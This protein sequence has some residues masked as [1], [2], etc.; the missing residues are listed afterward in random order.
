[1]PNIV[2]NPNDST[3]VSLRKIVTLATG[4]VNPHDSTEESLRKVVTLLGNGAGGTGNTA[5]LAETIAFAIA[6]G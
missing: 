4:A 3:E 5:S 2:S 6:L 1:M